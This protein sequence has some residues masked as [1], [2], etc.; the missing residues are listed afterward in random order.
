MIRQRAAARVVK[1]RKVHLAYK[2]QRNRRTDSIDYLG[3]VDRFIGGIGFIG[4]GP[5]KLRCHDRCAANM[6]ETYVVV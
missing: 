2:R 4:D 1:L 6:A 5:F 3:K